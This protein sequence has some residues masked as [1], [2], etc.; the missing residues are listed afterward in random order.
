MKSAPSV[1]ASAIRK[2]ATKEKRGGKDQDR[3]ESDRNIADIKRGPVP[4]TRVKIKE[5]GHGTLPQP[6]DDVAKRP[7]HDQ[8]K[9]CLLYTSPSPRD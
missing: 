5:I 3:A 4:V 2:A 8:R 9:T 6:V 7:A 1:A